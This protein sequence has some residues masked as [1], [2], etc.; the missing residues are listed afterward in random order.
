[1]KIKNLILVIVLGTG[2]FLNVSCASKSSQKESD[3][4]DIYNVQVAKL[5]KQILDNT[6]EFTANIEAWEKIIYNKKN[7]LSLQKQKL[8]L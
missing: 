1:M 2:I 6:L 8:Y 5:E 3:S 7:Y 4:D